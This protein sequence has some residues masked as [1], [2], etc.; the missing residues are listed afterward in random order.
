MIARHWRGWTMPENADA[1]ES[2]LKEKVLPGLKGIA[3]YRGGYVLRREIPDAVEFVVINLFDSLDA[4]KAFAGPDY[5][6]A[7]FEPE[8][9]V[10]LAKVEPL[11]AHYEVRVGLG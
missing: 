11:A 8:A 2:L 6:V 7:V 3:G 10:L 9:R 1:Y 5:S 4:V